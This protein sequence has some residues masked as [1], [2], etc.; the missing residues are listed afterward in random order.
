MMMV[1]KLTK[2]QVVD[3][4]AVLNWLFS[5]SVTPHFT[6]QYVWDILASTVHKTNRSHDQAIKELADTNEE[7][8][9]VRQRMSVDD[10]NEMRVR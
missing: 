7:L 1:D 10:E 6:Q 3:V 9:K 5:E 8:K 2:M 4:M